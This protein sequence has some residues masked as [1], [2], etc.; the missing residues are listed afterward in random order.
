MYNLKVSRRIKIPSTLLRQ[1]V[2]VF[3]YSSIVSK[4]VICFSR[5]VNKQ[6]LLGP[7]PVPEMLIYFFDMNF[8]VCTNLIKFKMFYV[9]IQANPSLLFSNH[10]LISIS[11]TRLYIHISLF[12]F[13][14]SITLILQWIPCV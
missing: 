11:L 5:S 7:L 6:Y 4:S 9:L 2:S 14:M 12:Q 1:S 10:S 8:I 13:L 3:G